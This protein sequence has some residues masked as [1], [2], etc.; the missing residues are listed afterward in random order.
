MHHNAFL[1][2][3]FAKQ[4]HTKLRGKRL[5][6]VY[7]TSKE[8]VFFVFELE[9][10]E[11]LFFKGQLLFLF[12]EAQDALPRQKLVQFSTFHGKMVHC[13]KAHPFD[14][15]FHMELGGNQLHFQCFGRR[16]SICSVKNELM[17]E[18]FPQ[19]IKAVEPFTLNNP[20]PSAETIVSVSQ[21]LNE[22]LLPFLRPSHWQLLQNMNFF[23]S[24]V[25]LEIWNDFIEH[26]AGIQ[27]TVETTENGPVVR[28]SSDHAPNDLLQLLKDFSKQYQQFHRREDLRSMLLS[29][30]SKDIH[31]RKEWIHKQTYQLEKQR[32]KSYAQMA[33]ILMANLHLDLNRQTEVELYDFYENKNVLIPLKKDLNLQEN[34]SHYYKKAKKQ[35]IELTEREKSLDI[36]SKALVELELKLKSVE[37]ASDYRTLRKIA[38]QF[39]DP[40]ESTKQSQ[41]PFRVLEFKG[42]EIWLGNNSK[43]NDAVFKKAHKEDLWLHVKD[44][45][46]SHIVVRMKGRTKLP[47]EVLEYVASLAAYHSKAKGENIAAVM[48]TPRKFVRK[49]KGA[50]PGQVKV[51]REQVLLVGPNDWLNM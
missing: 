30:I 4:L 34:A 38:E 48:Y 15:S 47:N 1:L 7:S 8:Q 26:M 19:G 36:A 20:T 2:E 9:V 41:L 39:D 24:E 25:P 43:Q 44:K 5:V 22:K 33:D 10:L 50:L 6:E 42:F 17:L 31:K 13:V 46:G 3:Q 40:K 21:T 49:F 27:Y 37:E 51:D 11:C 14:R 16:S 29:R 32:F 35:H 23:N 12:H 28:M 45:S 18:R